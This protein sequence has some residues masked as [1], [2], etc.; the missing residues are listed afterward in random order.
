MLTTLQSWGADWVNL[1]GL[2]FT[3]IRVWGLLL[4][5]GSSLATAWNQGRPGSSPSLTH[6]HTGRA[7]GRCR[8]QNI[9][10]HCLQTLRRASV[11][12]L[13]GQ[14]P[15]RQHGA[16]L[17]A[18]APFVESV[19]EQVALRPFTHQ[20]GHRFISFTASSLDKFPSQWDGTSTEMVMWS[21]VAVCSRVCVASP[22]H[23]LIS[24]LAAC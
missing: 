10:R 14:L 21:L 17:Q 18:Q 1:D 13:W 23:P 19:S 4:L 12:D 6:C 3:R 9:P 24:S 2:L 11:E 15:G 5:P 16:R 20:Q 7:G 22:K 8:Q